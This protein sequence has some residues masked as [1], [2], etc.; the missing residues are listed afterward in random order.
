MTTL[1]RT[2]SAP[3]LDEGHTGDA[4][5][6]IREVVGSG[7]MAERGRELDSL[8]LT[9]YVALLALVPLAFLLRRS[10]MQFPGRLRGDGST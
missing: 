2:V 9:P 7:P 6:R 4:A 1:A 3:L 5:S 8:L 10:G